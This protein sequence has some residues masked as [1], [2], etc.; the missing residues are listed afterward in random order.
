MAYYVLYSVQY[1]DVQMQYTLLY[2]STRCAHTIKINSNF[3]TNA[4][5][6]V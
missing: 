6:K 4:T 3:T 2:I 1:T 5:K